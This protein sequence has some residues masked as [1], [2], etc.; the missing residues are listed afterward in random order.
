MGARVAS[1]ALH[2]L[3]GGESEFAPK[4]NPVSNTKVSY[5]I[6]AGA[7]NRDWLEPNQHFGKALTVTDRV[8]NIYNSTDPLLKRY[9]KLYPLSLI[10]I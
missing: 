9:P 1:C 8:L 4:I 2:L 10:H 7:I 6:V 5:L 3:A